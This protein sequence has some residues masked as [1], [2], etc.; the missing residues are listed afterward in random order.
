MSVQEI[1]KAASFPEA[2]YGY[3]RKLLVM[4]VKEDLIHRTRHGKYSAT[5]RGVAEFVPEE[6][7][8]DDERI[9]FD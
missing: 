6:D 5:I 7:Y 2:K 9:N 8:A 3:L 1:L 4:M